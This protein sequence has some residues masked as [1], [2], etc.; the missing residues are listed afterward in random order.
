MAKKEENADARRESRKKMTVAEAASLWY[1]LKENAL[2]PSTRN[3]Y[4][5]WIDR[6]IAPFFRDCTSIRKEG[7]ETF[8]RQMRTCGYKP[9]S[10]RSMVYVINSIVE[11]AMEKKLLDNSEGLYG[12]ANKRNVTTVVRRIMAE[13]P[14][15]ETTPTIENPRRKK[16]YQKRATIIKAQEEKRMRETRERDEREKEEYEKR[17]EELA[18]E[19]LARRERVQIENARRKD[20]LERRREETIKVVDDEIKSL[21]VEK[22]K[23]RE[24]FTLMGEVYEAI[25]STVERVSHHTDMVVKALRIV[26][27]KDDKS[28]EALRETLETIKNRQE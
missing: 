11:F 28:P 4:K 13:N 5:F 10:V 6:M 12:D 2:T 27:E 21:M 8:V 26:V 17:K 24:L 7:I 19:M 15:V 16:P 14:N 9:D 3:N 20:M 22:E 25:S 18:K 1:K 23:L